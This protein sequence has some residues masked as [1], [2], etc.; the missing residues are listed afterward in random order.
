[1]VAALRHEFGGHAVSNV[2]SHRQSVSEA[3]DARH[4]VKKKD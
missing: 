4:D 2:G 3:S 1:M